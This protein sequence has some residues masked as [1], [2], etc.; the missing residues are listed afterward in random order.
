[1]DISTQLSRP[2]KAG[3]LVLA[4]AALATPVAQAGDNHG[5]APLASAA[6]RP[7]VNLRNDIAHSGNRPRF[8][9]QPGASAPI[10]VSVEGGFDWASAGA[11][12][13]GGFGLLLGLGGA[14]SVIRAHR[15]G[16]GA[17]S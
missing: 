15:R 12:A 5:N 6:E 3:A 9:A 13:A 4:L 7:D 1:M 2:L 14:A 11:G 16:T 8:S 10:I 17:L